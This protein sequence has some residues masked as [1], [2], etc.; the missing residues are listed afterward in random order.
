MFLVGKLKSV[1]YREQT[2]SNIF[3]TSLQCDRIEHLTW[4]NEEQL[5]I[6]IV[7]IANFSYRRPL[8]KVPVS[9]A[10]CFVFFLEYDLI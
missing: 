6:L 7:S 9:L 4:E 3:A 2:K 10:F 5:L 1:K 8:H